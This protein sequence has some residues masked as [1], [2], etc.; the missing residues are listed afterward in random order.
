MPKYPDVTVQLV[1][2]DGNA[3]AIIGRVSHALRKEVGPD[4][5]REFTVT[6]MSTGSY[7]ELLRLI[8]DTVEVK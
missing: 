1:G 4:A 3:F 6:A 7:D 2:E 5:A 8:T